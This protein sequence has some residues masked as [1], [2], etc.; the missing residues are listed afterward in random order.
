MA[1]RG[2]NNLPEPEDVKRCKFGGSN[3]LKAKGG[4]GKHVE[5]IGVRVTSKAMGTSW[6]IWKHLEFCQDHRS[7]GNYE[8]EVAKGIEV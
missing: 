5:K 7:L 1:F 4:C 8:E 6:H 3:N 2:T